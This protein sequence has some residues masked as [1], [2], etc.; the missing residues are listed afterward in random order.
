MVKDFVKQQPNH[1]Y[2]MGRI[3]FFINSDNELAMEF[4]DGDIY[5]SDDIYDM[6]TYAE[7]KGADFRFCTECGRPFD[8]GYTNEYVYYCEECRDEMVKNGELTVVD[9]DGDGGYY[10]DKDGKGTGIFYTEWF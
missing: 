10:L 3:K 4:E 9:D 6:E 7:D 1:E 5:S 2:D 8:Y